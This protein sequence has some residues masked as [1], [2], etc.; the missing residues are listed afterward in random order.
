MFE[1]NHLNNACIYLKEMMI[2]FVPS[3]Q[4]KSVIAAIFSESDSLLKINVYLFK[5]SELKITP[6]LV[7]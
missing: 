7:V 4:T 3:M 2:L 5:N 1:I 6:N